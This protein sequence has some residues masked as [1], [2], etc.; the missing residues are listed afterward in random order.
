MYKKI[1]FIK[2]LGIAALCLFS[3]CSTMKETQS[4]PM[5][6]I[7]LIVLAPG[8]FHAQLVQKEMYRQV[9]KTVHVYAP[10][11][12]EVQEYLKAISDYNTRRDKPTSW[13]E[14][15]YTGPDYFQKM[16]SGKKGNLVVLAG[17]NGK[18]IDYIKRSVDAGLNVLADK[19]MVIDAEGFEMLKTAFESAAK[20]KVLV[21]DI[22]TERYEI[23]SMLQRELLQDKAVFGELAAGTPE[24]PAI[25]QESV[26]HFFKYVSGKP[27][28]RPAWYYDVAQQ[29]E[30][31]VDVTTHL[32]D[33]VQWVCFPDKL[34]DYRKDIGIVNA[35]HWPTRIS[36]EQFKRSTNNGSWPAYLKKYVHDG[37]LDVYS[38]GEM[39]YTIKGKYAKIGVTWNFRAPEGGGDT[40]LSVVRGTKASLVIEQ[41]KAQQYRP[42]LYVEPVHGHTEQEIGAALLKK[43][44]LLQKRYPGVSVSR[45]AKGW[46]VVVPDVLRASHE[47][48]F[49]EVTRKYLNFLNKG[50][51][52]FWEVPNMLAKYYVTTQALK[53]AQN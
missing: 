10:Q 40:H 16:L 20:K 33:L 2:G 49:A 18:K 36:P 13:Y 21:Y 23:T 17:N 34:I 3:N 53:K 30:G 29:G 43:M 42:E 38:N 22:M 5:R 6:A 41:G 46:K 8:H 26:H 12:P 48:Q 14:L 45:E 4:K 25:I 9:D 31:V 7:Q 11:G 15:V 50:R 39:V 47:A 32:A 37:M 51:M 27:L 52:P 19:P 44:Q 1:G 24:N 35:K 28:I